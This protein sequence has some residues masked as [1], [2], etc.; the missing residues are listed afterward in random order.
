MTNGVRDGITAVRRILVLAGTALLIVLAG[1]AGAWA[2]EGA[3]PGADDTGDGGSGVV[4]DAGVRVVGGARTTTDEHPWAVFLTDGAGFQFCGGTLVA[5]TKVLTAA[6]CMATTS[7]QQVMVVAGRDDKQSTTGDTSAVTS[8]WV[9]PEFEGVG[10]GAD[11]AVLTLATPS[12]RTPLPLAGPGDEA[13]YQDGRAAQV[14]GWGATSESATPS[15]YLL[16]ATVPVRGDDYCRAGDRTFDARR[17]T[18]AGFDQGGVDSCQGDS[19]GPL[20]AAGKLIG[21]TSFGDG[22][23]R[24]GRPGYYVRVATLRDA[25]RSQLT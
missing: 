17:L 25:L 13:L 2:S 23:A 8:A 5:P 20:V 19:G 3:T 24:A 15:R 14:Y 11:L 16:T 22:C 7:P 10:K 21:V 18:C 4:V 12:T 9:S 6:H 1:A